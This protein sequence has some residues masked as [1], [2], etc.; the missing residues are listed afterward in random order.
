MSRRTR[1][2]ENDQRQK[3]RD[4]AL[5]RET[6]VFAIRRLVDPQSYELFANANNEIVGEIGGLGRLFVPETMGVS[7]VGFSRFSKKYKH[8]GPDT[9]EMVR[10]VDSCNKPLRIR[11]GAFGIY[12]SD[13]KIKL[14]VEIH[15]SELYGEVN[16]LSRNFREKGHPLLRDRNVDRTNFLHLSIGLLYSPAEDFRDPRILNRL[17]ETADLLGKQ[18]VL[19]SVVPPKFH[20]QQQ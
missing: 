16:M 12:G 3:P 11:L 5:G 13:K 6:S 19:Q 2:R 15:S 14:G 10:S 4:Q 8:E 17:E 20:T 7:V 9:E 1:S 18:V